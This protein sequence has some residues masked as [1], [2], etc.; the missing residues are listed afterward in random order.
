MLYLDEMAYKCDFCKDIHIVMPLFN[1][2]VNV[3]D[4]KDIHVAIRSFKNLYFKI[5]TG[6]PN[7]N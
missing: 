3:S 7:T 2:T 1:A 4:K 6:W 5:I